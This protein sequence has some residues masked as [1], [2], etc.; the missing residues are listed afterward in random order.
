MRSRLMTQLG[1]R[2]I[3]KHWKWIKL[4]EVEA[5]LWR[6]MEDWGTNHDN[7]EMCVKKPH[8]EKASSVCEVPKK[9]YM[10]NVEKGRAST[11]SY[12]SP[13]GNEKT[14]PSINFFMLNIIFYSIM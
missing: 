9:W 3:Q 2:S 4:L 11:D 10:S 1:Q 5:R 14:R 8:R 13:T 7:D 6:D 12:Q